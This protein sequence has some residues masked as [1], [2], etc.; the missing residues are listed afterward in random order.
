MKLTFLLFPVLAFC[1]SATSNAQI[2]TTIAGSSPVLYGG[3]G[4]HAT[5]AKL[6]A[7]NG[8]AIDAMGNI[9]IADRGNN[10]IRK[11]DPTGI[12][13]TF[14]GTGIG[15]FSG[16]GGAATDAALYL[17]TGVAVDGSGNVYIADGAN[18]RVRKI[19]SSGIIST[20]AGNGIPGFYGD[21]G[22]ATL[23]SLNGPIGVAVDAAGNIFIADC[24]NNVIRKINSSGI[25]STVAGSGIASYSGDGGPAVIAALNQPIG[26]A[27]DGAGNL[28]IG[29]GT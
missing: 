24:N 29:I 1:F 16:D 27:V 2:I 4:G 8:V 6:N 7:P 17:P 26:I 20:I 12:I 13:T 14:A 23:A 3:D 22:A 9:F 11:I 10:R 21:G 19:N 5:D 28:F 25:I 18:S 15:T